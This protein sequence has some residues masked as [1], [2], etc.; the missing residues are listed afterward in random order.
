M[1]KRI[2]IL[3][4]LLSF[5]EQ[6]AAGEIVAADAAKAARQYLTE[7]Q[8]QAVPDPVPI[9]TIAG[10][11]VPAAFVFSLHPKG[12]IIMAADDA[13]YPVLAWSTE[14]NF[15]PENEPQGIRDWLDDYIKQIEFIR[16]QKIPPDSLSTVTWTRLLQEDPVSPDVNPALGGIEPMLTS[17]WGQGF[18]YNALCP[19]EPSVAFPY[20]GHVPTGCGATAM[21]MVMNYWR[22]PLHG[23]GYHC[24]DPVPVPYG[25]Q[26]A[27]FL[28]ST[29]EWTG[30]VNQPGQECTPMALLL[31][32]AGIAIDMDYNPGGS[33][34]SIYSI[35]VALKEYFFYA[36]TTQ[37]IERSGFSTGTWLS[38]LK[39]DLSS[40]M[41]LV[42]C[43]SGTGSH[44]FVCDGYHDDNHFHFN[45]GWD[46]MYNGWFYL[47][48][49]NPGGMNFTNSQA[50]VRGIRPQT[51]LY[52]PYCTGQTTLNKYTI[53]SI[54]DGSG[55]V[56][57]YKN[58]SDCRWL[59]LPPDSIE[60]ITLHFSRFSIGPADYLSIYDGTDI[61]A[62]L[63]GSF[64]GSNI[65][66]DVTSTGPAMLV[67]M[68]SG[69]STT[70]QGFYAEYSTTPVPFCHP[71]TILMASAGDITDGSD[72][73]SYR[74]E[75]YCMWFI[76]PIGA[77]TITLSFSSFSTEEGKDVVN[78]Y[79]L[80]SPDPIASFSGTEMIPPDIT[81][82]TGMMMIEFI[83]DKLNKG[84]GWDASYSITVDLEEPDCPR[85]SIDPNPM[86]E[87]AKVNVP[88]FNT[89][90]ELLFY[91]RDLTG[92]IVLSCQIR[93]M[94]YTLSR[95]GIPAGM[96]IWH[97]ISNKGSSSGKLILE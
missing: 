76:L 35:P 88:D 67:R 58:Q 69:F 7:R 14:S 36:N 16:R 68:T 8:V 41:P 92:R 19:A 93:Q 94:P 79:N 39:S 70:L 49:L 28:N 5:G 66:T 20:Y 87:H 78:I 25:P 21:G 17:N 74:N 53:G 54:E 63:L 32:H 50:A 71:D 80:S 3:V 73:Y 59:I 45:W 30:I 56:E 43:G 26:C 24:I 90:E 47:D 48:N 91:L 18:P 86:H 23:I 89:G 1:M 95:D 13:A 10:P 72:H 15:A 33:Y 84:Q 60:S 82:T 81:S 44:I 83:T 77:Q 75:S 51:N 97:I 61:N 22:H 2:L 34:S 38:L 46:G 9:M 27:D 40:S 29:Y 64:T 37:V 65:P 57:K 52:P 11:D 55:P 62:A 4:F 12:F 31:Y 96:Y 85:A 6:I 42:Y